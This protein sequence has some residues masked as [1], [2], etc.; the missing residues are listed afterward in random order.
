MLGGRVPLRK[1]YDPMDRRE[2]VRLFVVLCGFA[3]LS[4]AIAFPAA[5]T[6]RWWWF[7]SGLFGLIGVCVLARAA[8][9]LRRKRPW[10]RLDEALMFSHQVAW[11]V[12]FGLTF[13]VRLP[14]A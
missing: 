11:V 13:W 10:G 12:A 14:R 1:L 6:V 8:Y 2:L 5:N 4:V 7:G 9:R 3:A